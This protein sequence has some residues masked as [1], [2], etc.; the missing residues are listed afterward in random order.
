MKK[1]NTLIM[2]NSTMTPSAM[3]HVMV[4]S[5]A[6][7]TEAIVVC[8]RS[9]RPTCTGLNVHAELPPANIPQGA[10]LGVEHCSKRSRGVS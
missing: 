4:A 3:V 2:G 9:Y 10:L 8:G 7:I 5:A 1:N 6:F